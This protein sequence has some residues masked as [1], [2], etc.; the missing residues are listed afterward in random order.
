MN[1]SE[2]HQYQ[3]TYMD[4]LDFVR[5]SYTAIRIFQTLFVIKLFIHRKYRLIYKSMNILEP[6][7]KPKVLNYSVVSKMES[8][9][10]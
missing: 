9:M 2:G 6:E 8:K 10:V 5:M 3:S 1:G 7:D 4:G